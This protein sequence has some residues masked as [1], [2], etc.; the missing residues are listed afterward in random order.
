MKLIKLANGNAVLA[1]ILLFL[2]GF[3]DSEFFIYAPISMILTGV[4]QTILALI[5]WVQNKKNI[6]ISFYFL[7]SITFFLL[8]FLFRD[9]RIE[10]ALNYPFWIMPIALCFYLTYIIH[11]I[12]KQN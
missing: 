12:E 6:L 5:L 4:I 2:I 11:T 9:F 8:F 7:F 3:F 1:P 10:D